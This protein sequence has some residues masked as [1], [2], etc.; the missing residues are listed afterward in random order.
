MRAI[1]DQGFQVFLVTERAARLSSIERYVSRE[2]IIG[3]RMLEISERQ[4]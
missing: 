2:T 3:I 1:V 4:N